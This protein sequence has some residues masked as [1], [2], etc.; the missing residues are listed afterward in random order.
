LNLHNYISENKRLIT[1][2]RQHYITAIFLGLF[3]PHDTLNAARIQISWPFFCRSTH[4]GSSGR[5]FLRMESNTSRCP[6]D[7]SHGPIVMRVTDISR[8]PGNG[9]FTVRSWQSSA[10]QNESISGGRIYIYMSDHEELPCKWK[11]TICPEKSTAAV[12]AR[13]KWSGYL[14]I[15]RETVK[16]KCHIRR[17]NPVSETSCFQ[18]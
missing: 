13:K 7:P 15:G 10:L 9:N 16:R 14:E 12:F 1:A 17:Q 2:L 3:K 18:M 4:V 5:T 8:R 11:M 6:P